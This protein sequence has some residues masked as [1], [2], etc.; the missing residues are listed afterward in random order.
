[1][2]SS[3][4]A[5]PFALP[6][7][8]A[9]R[10]RPLTAEEEGRAAVQLAD[11]SRLIRALIPDI[12]TRITTGTLDAG[13]VTQVCCAVARRAMIGLAGGDGVTQQ[14]Q[15]VGPFALAQ[16]YANPTGGQFLR[17]DELALLK[18]TATAGRSGRAFAFDLSPASE[19][20]RA[21]DASR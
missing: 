19:R 21:W 10:W 16:S 5:E 6:N 4:C 12:A 11:A 20:F 15:T 17:D 1:M 14:S 18:G 2:G 9:D 3:P 8:L 7:D 13:L